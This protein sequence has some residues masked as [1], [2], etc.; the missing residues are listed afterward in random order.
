MV[1]ISGCDGVIQLTANLTD[2]VSGECDIPCIGDNKFICGGSDRI[3]IY[4]NGTP[5]PKIPTVATR[6]EADDALPIGIWQYA[7]CYRYHCFYFVPYD[8]D[9]VYYSD[10]FANRTLGHSF[11]H[12]VGNDANSCAAVCEDAFPDSSKENVV[13]PK[14]EKSFLFSG[15]EFGGE[16]CKFWFTE[17]IGSNIIGIGCGT[18]ISSQAQILPDIACASMGC[19]GLNDQACGGE[20]VI[21]VYQFNPLLEFNDCEGE[22]FFTPFQLN[23]VFVDEPSKS[24][25]IT[26]T[27]LILHTSFGVTE[28]VPNAG[29]LSVFLS[30]SHV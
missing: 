10:S 12:G 23:A 28:T 27:S 26:M 19:F 21:A 8:V 7:G 6:P 16:C 9:P 22:V 5:S 2:S 29:I 25:P 4:T 11:S 14:S 13:S 24:V 18:S 30:H 1:C 3:S 17:M 15:V 20:L